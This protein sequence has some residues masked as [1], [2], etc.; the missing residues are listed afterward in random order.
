[1]L[2]AGIGGLTGVIVWVAL[3]AHAQLQ[4]LLADYVQ[5]YGLT[6]ARLTDGQYEPVTARHS[7][8]TPHWFSS[9]LML[10]APRHS[11]HH[12]HPGRPYPALR[13]TEN[14]P[15]LPWPLPLA[16]ALAMMP[17]LWR[18]LMRPHLQ[19]WQQSDPQNPAA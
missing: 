8:N 18:R 16:C 3:S 15:M 9:A 17:R 19:R 5:H 4:Q 7:W 12:A 2:A 13:L 11:D 6:R 14:A 1:V 10:N